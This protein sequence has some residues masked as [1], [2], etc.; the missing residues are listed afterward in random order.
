MPLRDH[1]ASPFGDD[2]PWDGFHGA[3]AAAIATHLNTSLL[4]AEYYAVPLVKRGG[5]VEIDVATFGRNG[6]SE[7]TGGS[8]VATAV[9]APPHPVRLGPLDFVGLDLFE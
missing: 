8:T 2:W 5:Q 1:F 6:V 3:W 9:W 7:D 4:P